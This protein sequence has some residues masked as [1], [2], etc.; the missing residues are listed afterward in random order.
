MGNVL[1]DAMRRPEIVPVTTLVAGALL[2]AIGTLAYTGYSYQV[3]ERKKD[4]IRVQMD[5]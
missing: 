5:D 2:S 1:T 4:I 3:R